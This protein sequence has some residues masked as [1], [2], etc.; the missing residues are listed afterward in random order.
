MLQLVNG[1]L[2][3][4]LADVTGAVRT[5]VDADENP[6]GEFTFDSFGNQISTDGNAPE[7]AVHGEEFDAVTGLTYMRAR[8]YDPEIGR[9]LARDALPA[10]LLNPSTNNAYTFVENNPLVKFDPSG[11][12]T[13]QQ[14]GTA[15]QYYCDA[16][17]LE[18]RAGSTRHSP[19]IDRGDPDGVP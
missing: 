14:L 17:N 2:Q 3:I 1:E 8:Y 10:S 7:F 5:T 4:P 12:F 18:Y 16:G 9:F 13:L 6:I 11:M 15:R 19:A